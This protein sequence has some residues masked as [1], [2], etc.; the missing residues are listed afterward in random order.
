MSRRENQKTGFRVSV[1]GEE[2]VFRGSAF[3][4]ERDIIAFHYFDRQK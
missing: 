4:K 3:R 2:C 1:Q